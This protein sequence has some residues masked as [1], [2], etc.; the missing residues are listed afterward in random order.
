MS[1][2]PNNTVAEFTTKLHERIILDGDSEV[3]LT[4]LIY[5]HSFSHIRNDDR[6]L[7]MEERRGHDGSLETIYILDN[8][9]Y[10][11]TSEF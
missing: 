3:A 9:Y 8:D 7:Y 6:S 11:N 4:E 1:F 2:F 10:E 5:T